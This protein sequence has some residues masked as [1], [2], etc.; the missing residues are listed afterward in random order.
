MATTIRK[1][2]NGWVLD[3]RS[4]L[5][6]YY[7]EQAGLAAHPPLCTGPALMTAAL[8][9][10]AGPLPEGLSVRYYNPLSKIKAAGTCKACQRRQEKRQ[11]KKRA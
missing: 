8:H 3:S 5:Y 9:R 1:K 7:Q 6:H 11:L 4:H 2:V 10:H